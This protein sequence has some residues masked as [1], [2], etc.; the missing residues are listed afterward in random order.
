[1]VL[2]LERLER[3]R[4]LVREA[5]ALARRAFEKFYDRPIGVAR[6]LSILGVSDTPKACAAVATGNRVA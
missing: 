4:G 2:L 5:G 3:D 6:I 1:M